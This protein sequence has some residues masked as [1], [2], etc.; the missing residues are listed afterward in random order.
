[1]AEEQPKRLSAERL[2]EYRNLAAVPTEL[3]EHADA[4]EAE[5]AEVLRERD[6][7]RTRCDEM[8]RLF[9]EVEQRAEA[10]EAR[11]KDLTA[12]LKTAIEAGI[13]AG[14]DQEEFE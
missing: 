6:L 10:A 1:M 8:I 14:I 12:K 3:I 4:I 2:A 9:D 11:I 7:A 5:L 13:S